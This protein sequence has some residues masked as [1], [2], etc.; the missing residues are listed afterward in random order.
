MPDTINDLITELLTTRYEVDPEEITPEAVFEDLSL[1]SLALMEIALVLEK[2]LGV[3]IQEGLLTTDQT[4][5][6]AVGVVRSLQ[7]A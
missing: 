2:R 7:P 1:D 6:E 4:L 3:R 5:G